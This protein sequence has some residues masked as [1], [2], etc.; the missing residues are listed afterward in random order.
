MINVCPN[1]GNRIHP[2]DCRNKWAKLRDYRDH[3]STSP[4]ERSAAQLALDRLGPE[5]GKAIPK[6]PQWT[7]PSR[8]QYTP[9]TQNQRYESNIFDDAA[10][11]VGMDREVF[12]Q[13]FQRI[14]GFDFVDGR[15]TFTGRY[16]T[17]VDGSFRHTADRPAPEP[18]PIEYVDVQY[19]NGKWK[20]MP[21]GGPGGVDWE[22]VDS[23][24]LLW[25]YTNDKSRTFRGKRYKPGPDRSSRPPWDSPRR[26]QF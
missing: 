6:P 13:M 21:A 26:R 16:R 3:P 18:E 19:P 1:C 9:P 5:P 14:Y 15:F 12:R 8:P 23:Q 10:D 25:R 17:N 7:P 4:E 2:E 24:G 11:S 22:V 20:T